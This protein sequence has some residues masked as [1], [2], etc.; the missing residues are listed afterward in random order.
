M[1][2]RIALPVALL[3]FGLRASGAELFYMDH[4]PVTDQF[5]GPVGPLVISGEIVAGDYDSL[6]AKIIEDEDRFLTQNKILLASDGGDVTEA[7]RIAKFIKSLYA[8]VIVGPAT[9]R[10]VSACFFIYAAANQREVDGERLLGINRPYFDTAAPVAPSDAASVESAGLTQVR[11]FLKDNAVPT[12]LV[13]EMFR[14]GSNEAYWLSA[15]D[16]RNLGFRSASFTQFL[17]AKCAWDDRI[18]H[19]AYAGKGSFD[20]LKQMLKCR[21]RVTREAAHQALLLARQQRPAH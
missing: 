20:D 21:E 16:A 2:R 5:V 13:E 3:L 7:L 11:A 14:R 1:R 17:A 8:A 4:D 18:E 10:C 12:Y 6:V 9:G 15:D 19:E